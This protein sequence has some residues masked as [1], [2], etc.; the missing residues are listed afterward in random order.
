MTGRP[1]SGV[2][3]RRPTTPP[4]PLAVAPTLA[5]WDRHDH[6]SQRALAGFLS[7]L[8]PLVRPALQ[9]LATP[10]VLALDVGLP[11]STSLTSGGRDLDN[12][13]FPIVTR[14]G[15]ARFA[16]V[17]ARKHHGRSTLA[18]GPA[19][20]GDDGASEHWTHGSA[21]LTTSSVTTAWKQQLAAGLAASTEVRVLPPGPVEVRLA[22][23]VGPQRNWANLW[24][25]AIDALGGVLGV[26]EP[27][28]PFGPLDDRITDLE[29]QH[30]VD[31]GIGHAVQVDIWWRSGNRASV[32]NTGFRHRWTARG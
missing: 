6:P 15:P 19:Q 13:V 25:P 21:F 5:S 14:F 24:K 22:F 28:K 2:W 26:A 3:Y 32:S 7:S 23:Q 27:A 4:V 31:P 12:Y 29:L 10:A 17:F 9:V 11:K 16:A 8:E 20:L 1:S 18:I 30:S